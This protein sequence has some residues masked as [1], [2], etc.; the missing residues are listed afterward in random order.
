MKKLIGFLFLYF[1]LITDS[2][3]SL[4]M[5]EP[6]KQGL[7]ISSSSFQSRQLS[8]M[9]VAIDAAPDKLSPL[10]YK[11]F[12]RHEIMLDRL[13]LT[14]LPKSLARLVNAKRLCLD[15]NQLY[16]IPDCIKNFNHLTELSVTHNR[17]EN[18]PHFVVLLKNLTI[19]NLSNNSISSFN[20]KYRIPLNLS[21]LTKLQELYLNKNMISDIPESI[22]ELKCLKVLSLKKNN[23]FTLPECIGQLKNLEAL[24]LRYNKIQELPTAMGNMSR[25]K[26]LRLDHNQIREIPDSF[27]NMAEL[28]IL[29]IAGNFFI[30]VPE[31]FSLLNNL[32]ILDIRDNQIESI[33]SSPLA[34]CHLKIRHGVKPAK[35]KHKR[36]LNLRNHLSASAQWNERQEQ[37]NLHDYRVM[38]GSGSLGSTP[39]F[40]SSEDKID[41]LVVVNPAFTREKSELASSWIK[42]DEY[43]EDDNPLN[44][45]MIYKPNEQGPERPVLGSSLVADESSEPGRSIMVQPL[46]RAVSLSLVQQ[47]LAF[48]WMVYYHLLNME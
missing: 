26:A 8:T 48:L 47:M 9:L 45:T 20:S 29:K 6:P 36:S 25:L 28:C 43:S 46:D 5:F 31:M 23:I 12:E 41:S 24:D 4:Y 32:V 18:I 30:A 21:E 16:S 7:Y 17:L 34:K 11:L 37:D 27:K 19:L 1:V 38:H 22:K 15:Y 13:D 40:S 33:P 44:R 14:S 3:A 35:Q 42:D 39:F 10:D 2:A